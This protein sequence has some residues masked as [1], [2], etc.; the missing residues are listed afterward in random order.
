MFVHGSANRFFLAIVL[1]FVSTVIVIIWLAD[2]AITMYRLGYRL[3]LKQKQVK[4]D[5]ANVDA[6]QNE[7]PDNLNVVVINDSPTAAEELQK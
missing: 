7:H 1:G 6:H 3:R 5:V 4:A 2:K